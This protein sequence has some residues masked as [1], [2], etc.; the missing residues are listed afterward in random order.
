MC[1]LF[2]FFSVC[3]SCNLN[4]YDVIQS[5]NFSQVSVLPM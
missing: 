3:R 4:C 1:G 2:I 5:A